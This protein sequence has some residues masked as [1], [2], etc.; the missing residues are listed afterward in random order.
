MNKKTPGYVEK[1][2]LIWYNTFIKEAIGYD[3]F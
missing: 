3:I 1:E 2:N